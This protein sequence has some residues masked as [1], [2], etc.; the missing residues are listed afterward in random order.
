MSMCFWRMCFLSLSL[1][2]TSS[3][4]LKLELESFPHPLETHPLKTRG[5]M[6]SFKNA[7]E[8]ED[9]FLKDV[10]FKDERGVLKGW[11]HQKIT[12]V[13]AIILDVQKWSFFDEQIS[14]F[15]KKPKRH[16][17]ANIKMIPFL[18]TRISEICSSNKLSFWKSKIIAEYSVC[19]KC[20]AL[21]NF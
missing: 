21:K 2:N 20:W 15:P 5:K 16:N 6:R 10:F 9:V 14:G 7:R 8:N 4:S 11:S 1:K 19:A 12:P 17:C 3:S 18:M 13:A